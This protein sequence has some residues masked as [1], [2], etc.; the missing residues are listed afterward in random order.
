MGRVASVSRKTGET[1]IKIKLDIDGTGK[2]DINTG[3][4]FF[5]HM[6]D[7]F[8]RHGLFDLEVSVNGK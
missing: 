3:I 8:A 1:D 4:G 5:D 6:L 2:S 7:S